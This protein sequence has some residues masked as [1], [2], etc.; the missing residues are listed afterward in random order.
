MQPPCDSVTV[1]EMALSRWHLRVE[2][3]SSTLQLTGS[4]LA[5]CGLHFFTCQERSDIPSVPH[6]TDVHAGCS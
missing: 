4:A 2:G 3:V 1:R 5:A 6:T